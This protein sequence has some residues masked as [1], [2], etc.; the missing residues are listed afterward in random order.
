[1]SSRQAPHGSPSAPLG[2]TTTRRVMSASPAVSIVPMALRTEHRCNQVTLS[3]KQL[4]PSWVVVNHGD[5]LRRTY[6]NLSK[7]KKTPDSAGPSLAPSRRSNS[8]MLLA[9]SC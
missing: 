7:N 1:M 6:E 4:R 9:Q 5:V 3:G 8:T 2:I